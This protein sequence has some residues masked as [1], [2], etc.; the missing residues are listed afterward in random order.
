MVLHTSWF[1]NS[2]RPWVIYP[3]MLSTPSTGV[4]EVPMHNSST[5]S[6]IKLHR[7]HNSSTPAPSR[8]DKQTLTQ[9][10]RVKRTGPTEDPTA[11]MINHWKHT[12]KNFFF[13]FF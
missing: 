6:N 1:E 11:K 8:R 4:Y 2:A 12:K 3:G 13:F 7:H 9:V 5:I 10:S